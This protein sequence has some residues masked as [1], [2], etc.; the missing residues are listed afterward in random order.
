MTVEFAQVL[1]EGQVVDN[2]EREYDET[3]YV[4]NMLLWH[5]LEE[6]DKNDLAAAVAGSGKVTSTL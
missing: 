1:P 6:N 5:T 3:H 4:F 2:V